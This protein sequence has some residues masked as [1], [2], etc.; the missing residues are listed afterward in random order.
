MSNMEIIFFWASLVI[1]ALSCGG[2]IYSIV[3][4]NPR[5]L[6][7]LTALVAFG[8]LVHSAAIVAR[9]P[10]MFSASTTPGCAWPPA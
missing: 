1:Y 5:V 3:F 4:K 2:F 7:R 9:F 8:L 6:G 10:P